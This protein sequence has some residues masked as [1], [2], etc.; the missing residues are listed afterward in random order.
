MDDLVAFLRARLDEDEQVARA[1]IERQPYDEWDATGATGD[2]DA[3]LAH[4]EVVKIARPH[5]TP[6]ARAI[7][8]HIARW[9][10]ARVLAEVEAKRRIITSYQLFAT[11]PVQSGTYVSGLLDAILLLVQP[12]ADHPDYREE[13]RP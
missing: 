9:D 13:W 1:A 8:Q 11:D 7:A 5:P 4:A 6:A 3:A 2:D 12:Y 10:P